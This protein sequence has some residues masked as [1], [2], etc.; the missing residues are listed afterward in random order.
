[1]ISKTA[2]TTSLTNEAFLVCA[3]AYEMRRY[4]ADWEKAKYHYLAR[5]VVSG[6]RI[7]RNFLNKIASCPNPD[8]ALDAAISVFFE[9]L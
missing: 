5:A 6:D 9:E 7:C 2:V 4:G 8:L 3:I 1:M